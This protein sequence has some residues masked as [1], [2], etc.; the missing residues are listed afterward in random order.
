MLRFSHHRIPH[1]AVNAPAKS[2]NGFGQF[3]FFFGSLVDFDV[4][5]C[6]AVKFSLNFS[7]VYTK[8]IFL[9]ISLSV[10]GKRERPFFDQCV[11]IGY[12]RQRNR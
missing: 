4:C 10:F 8:I 12:V 11:T 1:P 7:T 6:S 2:R 3:F 9:F 5:E